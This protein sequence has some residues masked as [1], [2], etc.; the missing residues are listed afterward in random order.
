MVGG[1]GVAISG[2]KRGFFRYIRPE[3][4]QQQQQRNTPLHLGRLNVYE[5]T[6][7]LLCYFFF[8]ISFLVVVWFSPPP[9]LAEV[10]H[11]VSNQVDG[12]NGSE[13]RET[14]AAGERERVPQ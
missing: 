2:V 9:P 14:M 10:S 11:N 12:H 5:K 4:R 7:L 13:E 1:G 6:S 3:G 8:F